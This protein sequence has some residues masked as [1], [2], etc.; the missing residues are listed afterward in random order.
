M[1]SRWASDRRCVA[2]LGSLAHPIGN[3]LAAVA[4]Y[5]NWLGTESNDGQQGM[6]TNIRKC[7]VFA[8]DKK[9]GI[10]V[11]EIVAGLPIIVV[12]VASPA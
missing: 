1:L 2:D 7:V 11:S 10:S 9:F 5:Q 12:V 4:N 3:R 6:R 8:A